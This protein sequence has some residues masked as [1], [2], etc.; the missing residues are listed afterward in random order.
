LHSRANVF[1]FGRLDLHQAHVDVLPTRRLA[2]MYRQYISGW[3][4]CG[5][6]GGLDWRSFWFPTTAG[7]CEGGPFYVD[8]SATGI[9]I[10]SAGHVLGPVKAVGCNVVAV[11]LANERNTIELA[12]VKITHPGAIGVRVN[13]QNNTIVGGLMRLENASAVGV[14]LLPG[15]DG[16]AAKR[17]RM[18]GTTFLGLGPASGVAFSSAEPLNSCYIR[19]HFQNV[20]T[21]LDLIGGIGT[22]N[23]IWITTESVN[24]P[25]NITGTWENDNNEIWVDGVRRPGS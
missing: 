10:E 9:L 18:E 16:A 7:P 24:V 17:F 14:R 12:D 15:G 2:T 23:Y 6:G 1:L 8:N 3:L 5:A 11:D 20:G 21:A 25:L 19:G 13:S 4:N 22:G